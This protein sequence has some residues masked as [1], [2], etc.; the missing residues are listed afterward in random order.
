MF[1]NMVFDGI[2]NFVYII[3]VHIQTPIGM[4]ASF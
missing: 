2:Y 1:V 3:R 4:F